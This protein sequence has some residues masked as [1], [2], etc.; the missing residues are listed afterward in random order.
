MTAS[1]DPVAVLPR[2]QMYK[3]Y[4]KQL[5]FHDNAMP[6]KGLTLLSTNGLANV[7]GRAKQRPKLRCLARFFSYSVC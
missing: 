6:T 4:V 2:L 5:L 3:N 7:N 1:D